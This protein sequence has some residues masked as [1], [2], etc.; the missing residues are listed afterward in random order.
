MDV[1]DS[2]PLELDSKL[3]VLSGYHAF[4]INLPSSSMIKYLFIKALKNRSSNDR[5]SDSD[6]PDLRT[7]Y[8][9]NLAP[10]C[11]EK[12]LLAIFGTCGTIESIRFDTKERPVTSGGVNVSAA[13]SHVLNSKKQEAEIDDSAGVSDIQQEY[14][15]MKLRRLERNILGETESN[16][17]SFESS[18]FALVVFEE[19]SGLETA[20]TQ[21]TAM[22]G[23]GKSE[24]GVRHRSHGL[25]KWLK[26]WTTEKVQEAQALQKQAD[27][28][29]HLYDKRLREHKKIQEKVATMPDEDGWTLV[30]PRGRK[31]SGSSSSEHTVGAAS[32]SQ[33][34]LR[35]LKADRDKKTQLDDFYKFQQTDMKASRLDNLR[36][37]FAEDKAKIRKMQSQPS[38][39]KFNPS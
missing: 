30:A 7:L 17:Q 38:G 26:S 11:T 31:K 20:L 14:L 22:S 37:R 29:L 39:R 12:D 33:N 35:Q 4:P 6:H 21:L 13:L 36:K 5:S 1:D 34:Q 8:V 28:A 19:A 32:L 25:K 10:H 16:K 9:T 24:K 15:R 18:G 2:T 3:T 27:L 23:F